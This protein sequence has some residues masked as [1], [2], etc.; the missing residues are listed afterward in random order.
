MI[1]LVCLVL[2]GIFHLWWGGKSKPL[3]AQEVQEGIATLRVVASGP[4]SLSHLD[5]VAE[6]LSQDDGLS[7]VMFNTVLHRKKSAI[8]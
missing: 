8:P 2:Y 1:W 5:D 7:F 6:L 4:N 3:S